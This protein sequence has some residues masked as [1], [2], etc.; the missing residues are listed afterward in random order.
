MSEGARVSAAFIGVEGNFGFIMVYLIKS[1]CPSM[2]STF[3]P[4]GTWLKSLAKK[5]QTNPT[6][7]KGVKYKTEKN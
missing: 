1:T 7:V 3:I 6:S 2:Y 4:A 5:S